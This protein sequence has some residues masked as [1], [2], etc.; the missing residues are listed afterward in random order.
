MNCY[1]DIQRLEIAAVIWICW[2]VTHSLLNSQGVV[3]WILPPGNR[4]RPYYRLIYVVFSSITLGLVYWITPRDNDLPVLKWHGVFIAVPAVIWVIALAIGYLSFRFINAWDF[5]GLTVVGIGRKTRGT[6]D[7]LI[8]WGIY[9]E[10]RN[11]Q[12][13]VVLMLLWARDLT[14]TG[15]VINI[16]L[17][18]YLIS[19][20]FIEER[21]LIHKFGEDYVRY[22]SHVPRFIP[23]RLPP[24]R[25]LLGVRDR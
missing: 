23:R 20:A 9:G 22:R 11:P 13:L 8:T 3:A 14:C 12:F 2:C 7:K 10:I 21:R 1:E 4:I 6:S 25:Q 24:L 15:L 18:L 16:V 17:S 5:L 19:G